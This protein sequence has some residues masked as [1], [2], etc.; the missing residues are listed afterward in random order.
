[1][2]VPVWRSLNLA[3]AIVPQEAT[4]LRELAKN[5][6]VLEVGAA[7]GYSAVIMALAGAIH[8]TSI[9]SHRNDTWLGDTLT[10]MKANLEAF[11][12][13]DKVTIISDYSKPAM[14]KLISEGRKFGFI[15]LDGSTLP[16]ENAEDVRL[17]IQLL[18]P[19]GIISRHD[20]GHPNQPFLADILNS[21]FPQ[22]PDRI[23]NTLFEV[24]V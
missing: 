22:G 9:D 20:Y 18:E 5:R 3:T 17:G 8:V 12:V 23:T 16:E 11:G 15:F 24:T 13:E 4:R 6:T 2:I 10:T 1:M 19:G 7:N 14:E 21:A